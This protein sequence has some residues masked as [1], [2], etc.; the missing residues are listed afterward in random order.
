MHEPEDGDL[1]ALLAKTLTS[2]KNWSNGSF[3]C[4]PAATTNLSSSKQTTQNKT[5]IYLFSAI[6]VYKC[7]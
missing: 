6:S 2:N 3:P 7:S 1:M 4:S 5:K